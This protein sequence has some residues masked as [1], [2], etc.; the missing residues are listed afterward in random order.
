MSGILSNLSDGQ[1]AVF[2]LQQAKKDWERAWDAMQDKDA[3]QRLADKATLAKERASSQGPGSIADSNAAMR[4]ME[5]AKRVGGPKAAAEQRLE[6]VE[7]RMAELKMTARQAPGDKEKLA[8]LA[9][10]AAVLAREAGRAAKEY[11]SGV[12]A[13][14]EMG[15]PGDTGGGTSITETITRGSLTIVQTEVSVSLTV[16]ISADALAKLNQEA[17]VAA[18]GDAAAAASAAAM[19][20]AAVPT[21]A[22][23]TDGTTAGAADGAA[24]GAADGAAD[25]VDPGA[26]SAAEDPQ[27]DV[28]GSIGSDPFGSDATDDPRS[29]R[30]AAMSNDFG[31]QLVGRM[32]ADNEAKMSR[33]R[34]ADAFA[35]RVEKVLADA[36]NLIGQAKVANDLDES[37]QRR[38]ARRDAFKDYDKML[39]A[40]QKEANGLRQAAF[41]SSVTVQDYLDALAKGD[42][43]AASMAGADGATTAGIT[44]MDGATVQPTGLPT[45]GAEGGVASVVNL[46]A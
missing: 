15:L 3:S 32:M 14:A 29:S 7:R 33:Y 1:S 46:L 38:K 22:T 23:V 37:E 6:M 19:M 21:D 5:Q 36:K 28:A 31:R 20:A 18:Q 8:Q 30:R 2:R 17:P 12:A 9:R 45:G 16:T 41:G 4:A 40:A 44:G 42:S 11:G 13:A 10:E 26:T 24:A 43:G 34:E 35:R 39:D 25:G 27:A